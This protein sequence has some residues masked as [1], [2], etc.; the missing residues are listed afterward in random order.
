MKKFAV[1]VNPIDLAVLMIPSNSP[2]LQDYVSQGFQ[3][4]KLGNK[5][6]CSDFIEEFFDE[7]EILPEAQIYSIHK[8]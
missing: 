1:Y 2:D 8:N 3:F 7:H 6:E 5:R 4:K